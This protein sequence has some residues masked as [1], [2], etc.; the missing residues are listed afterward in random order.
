[1]GSCL[2]KAEPRAEETNGISRHEEAHS[3]KA[4]SHVSGRDDSAA[5]VDTQ[6]PS[7]AHPNGTAGKATA[8]TAA[9]VP[10]TDAASA[11]HTADTASAEPAATAALADRTADAA[12]AEAS[13]VGKPD[14]AV[15][16]QAAVLDGM[17]YQSSQFGPPRPGF[18]VRAVCRT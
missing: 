6:L 7:P 12:P 8:N 13:D 2:S 15:A 3:A 1:M 9:A 14:A 5:A 10:A 17:P 11:E 4:Q 18:Q 16:A